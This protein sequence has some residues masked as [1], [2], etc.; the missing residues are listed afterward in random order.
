MSDW[1]F[2]GAFTAGAGV[3]FFLLKGAA[4]IKAL[5][6]SRAKPK[7]LESQNCSIRNGQTVRFDLLV[8]NA[9]S[10]DC[11]IISMELQ[12]PN[13]RF[14][15]LEYE[16]ST[17]FPKA[18]PAERTERVKVYGICVETPEGQILKK[19]ELDPSQTS[20]KGKVKVRFNTNKILDKDVIFTIERT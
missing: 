4:T 10:K 5:L 16:G 20:I 15:D 6:P 9:G 19:L 17:P 7:L 18:I 13:G 11:A 8:D 14:A 3:C 2:L 12:W 1:S